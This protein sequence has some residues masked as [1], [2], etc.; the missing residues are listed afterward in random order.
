MYYLINLDSTITSTTSHS[1]TVT[2]SS[3]Q[4]STTAPA[5]LS[6]EAEIATILLPIIAFLALYF[7][8]FKYVRRA[9]RASHQANDDRMYRTDMEGNDM[10]LDHEKKVDSPE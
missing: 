10:S 7:G 5:S 3:P 1:S 2:A 4:F 8:V 6:E 9:R